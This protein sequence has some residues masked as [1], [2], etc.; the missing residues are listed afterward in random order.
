MDAYDLHD[1]SEFV[2]ALQL[3]KQRDTENVRHWGLGASDAA[4]YIGWVADQLRWL[5]EHRNELRR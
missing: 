1:R 3:A 4:D 2:T 5:D